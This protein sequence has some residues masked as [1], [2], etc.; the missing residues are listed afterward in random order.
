MQ[1]DEDEESS[2]DEDEKHDECAEPE[3]IWDQIERFTF[4][5]PNLSGLSFLDQLN[6]K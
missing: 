4:R 1:S 5:N 2:T 3:K 6:S